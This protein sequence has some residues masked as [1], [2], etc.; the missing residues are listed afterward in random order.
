M[1]FTWVGAVGAV[2]CNVEPMVLLPSISVVMF[3]VMVTIFTS[4]P[5]GTFDGVVGDAVG[6]EAL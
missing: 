2:F 1:V 4:K 6:T 3:V 5:A